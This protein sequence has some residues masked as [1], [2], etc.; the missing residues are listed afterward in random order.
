[1]VCILTC[2]DKNVKGEP[3]S[4]TKN[5]QQAVCTLET[6][7]EYDPVVGTIEESSTEFDTDIRLLHIS[8]LEITRRAVDPFQ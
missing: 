4:T 5:T 7:E 1:M 2:G 3:V 6:I 8:G